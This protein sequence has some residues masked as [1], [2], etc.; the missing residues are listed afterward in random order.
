MIT[1]LV[2][3]L[4]ADAGLVAQVGA[5]CWAGLLPQGSALPA[6]TFQQITRVPVHVRNHDDQFVSTRWQFNVDAASYASAVEAMN[7]LKV[8]LQAWTRTTSP[9]VGPVFVEGERDGSTP[10]Y[11]DADRFRRS[12]D[13]VIWHEE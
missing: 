2:A 8:A 3:Y 7:A 9:R 1:Y 11:D 6:V 13:A 5:R 12:I 10:G 4:K